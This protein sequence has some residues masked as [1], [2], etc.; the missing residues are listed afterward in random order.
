MS[1]SEFTSISS[2]IDYIDAC[3]IE[4]RTKPT[5]SLLQHDLTLLS[6]YNHLI[7]VRKYTRNGSVP[8]RRPIVFE[9]TAKKGNNNVYYPVYPDIFYI[10]VPTSTNIEAVYKYTINSTQSVVL[11]TSMHILSQEEYF[12]LTKFRYYIRILSSS[13]LIVFNLIDKN[14]AGL[15]RYLSDNFPLFVEI[16]PNDSSNSDGKDNNLSNSSYQPR[17]KDQYLNVLDRI[18]ILYQEFGHYYDNVD[19]EPGY[20]GSVDRNDHS[21]GVDLGS[22]DTQLGVRTHRNI[23]QKLYTYFTSRYAEHQSRSSV[24]GQNNVNPHDENKLFKIVDTNSTRI[25]E[26]ASII[27]KR[28]N[29]ISS[30]LYIGGF[31]VDLLLFYYHIEYSHAIRC[32]LL[33]YGKH[34]GEFMRKIFDRTSISILPI[35]ISADTMCDNVFPMSLLDK[36]KFLVLYKNNMRIWLRKIDN[37][38]QAHVYVICKNMIARV[39]KGKI[40]YNDT[41]IERSTVN[42]VYK[43]IWNNLTIKRRDNSVIIPKRINEYEYSR[44]Y[45]SLEREHID[46]VGYIN[47]LLLDGYVYLSGFNP[48]EDN[49][50]EW[51][52]IIVIKELDRQIML[53]YRDTY[54]DSY[55]LA[56]QSESYRQIET[57]RM[58]HPQNLADR[59]L[60]NRKTPVPEWFGPF[61]H[62]K[63]LIS[64]RIGDE[65]HYTYKSEWERQN[66]GRF[67]A[68]CRLCTA[69]CMHQLEDGELDN[70]ADEITTTAT[71]IAA[72]A[73]ASS[74]VTTGVSSGL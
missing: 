29:N 71:V 42:T 62:L 58:K 69:A 38:L 16:E 3:S 7:L 47:G 31:I 19:S 65:I 73:A 6:E 11:T 4:K 59:N 46:I 27:A 30:Y 28:Y 60:L 9:N 24:I 52:K 15:Y 54:R 23:I 64:V 14:S 8:Y 13:Q 44:R 17:A 5:T 40:Q 25:V 39:N 20:N 26:E 66:K 41:D 48:Y 43:S 63:P 37:G 70:I 10:G 61:N 74:T 55:P 22:R 21:S 49:I 45:K 18:T 57:Y 32:L 67:H 53:A 56:A 36:Y 68:S 34:G 72:A 12:I 1:E 51:M 35:A 50:E 2:F 33:I